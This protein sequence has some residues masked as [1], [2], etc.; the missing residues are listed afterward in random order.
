MKTI[1]L[2]KDDRNHAVQEIQAFFQKER[3]EEIG[4]LHA[5]FL[6]DF[7]L[8]KIGPAIYNQA[9]EDAHTL[10]LRQLEELYSLQ[11]VNRTDE[12]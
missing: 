12:V 2:K 9:I 10:L 5:E 6:L 7:V 11:K 4:N 8:E 1:K 3:N